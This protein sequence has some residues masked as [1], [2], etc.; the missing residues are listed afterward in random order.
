M[1]NTLR[2]RH[3]SAVD[4]KFGNVLEKYSLIA[5]RFGGWLG[6][7]G[8]MTV[9]YNNY[10]QPRWWLYQFYAKQSTMSWDF[11]NGRTIYTA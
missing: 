9:Q 6:L 2:T 1:L 8:E 4:I 3:F 7:C 5:L 11:F 10:T